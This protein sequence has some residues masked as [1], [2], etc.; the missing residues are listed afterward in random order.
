MPNVKKAYEQFHPK[1]FE[2]VGISFDAQKDAWQ[3]AT[4][5]LGITWPR[6][7]LG[8]ESLELRSRCHLRYTGIPATILF[9]PDGK[10]VATDLRR[11]N[12]RKV[13][14]NLPVT[15]RTERFSV[16][17]HKDGISDIPKMPSFALLS[18]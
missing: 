17:I 3:K 12:S 14:R 2:I 6:K 9:S 13:G 16:P 8:S 15:L 11:K 5:Q 10:I 1:G 4:T 18:Y 7:Y